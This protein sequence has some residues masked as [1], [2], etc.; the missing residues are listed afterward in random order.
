MTLWEVMHPAAG[1]IK[2]NRTLLS[3]FRLWLRRR[4]VDDLANVRT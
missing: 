1:H 3:G 4:K 2:G